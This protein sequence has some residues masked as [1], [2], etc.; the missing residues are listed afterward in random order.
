MQ[1]F[2]IIYT[3]TNEISRIN[4]KNKK[5]KD[6]LI[7]KK[8]FNNYV[9]TLYSNNNINHEWINYII[10]FE[11]NDDIHIYF[12][13]YYI[14]KVNKNDVITIENINTLF[15]EIILNIKEINIKLPIDYLFDILIEINLN[16]HILL[17]KKNKDN[18]IQIEFKIINNNIHFFI[19][20]NIFYECSIE[21]FN[22][23]QQDI[24]NKYISIEKN[25]QKILY[26]N[27]QANLFD[28]EDTICDLQEYM[29]KNGYWLDITFNF[30]KNRFQNNV[31]M[32]N[33]Y[34]YFIKYDIFLFS[35]INCFK[36]ILSSLDNNYIEE[37][38]K[39]KIFIFIPYSYSYDN[40]KL[41]WKYKDFF[42]I[43]KKNN[44]IFIGCRN[45]DS[46][47]RIS[48][49]RCQLVQ[50]DIHI[51]NY[52]NTFNCFNCDILIPVLNTKNDSVL[53]KNDFFKIHKLD[54]NKPLITFFIIWPIR[55]VNPLIISTGRFDFDNEFWANDG[56]INEFIANLKD[57]YNI[58]F[59]PHPG[60]IKID[61]N[62]LYINTDIYTKDNIKSILNFYN[63][64][65]NTFKQNII[66][67][68]YNHEIL[69]Y[70]DFGIVSY[71]STICNELY[72][73]DIPLL[74]LKSK[75]NDWT[76]ICYNGY[77]ELIDYLKNNK[78]N[79]NIDK[80][81]NPINIVYGTSEFIDNIEDDYKNKLNKIINKN[82]K[83]TYKYFKNHP[84]YGNTYD[85]KQK[86]IGKKILKILNILNNINTYDNSKIRYN[87]NKYNI[88][89]YNDKYINVDIENKIITIKI[90]KEPLINDHF[91]SYGIHLYLYS[92]ERLCTINLSFD[93]KLKL[94]EDNIYFRLYTGIKWIIYKDKP[95]TTNFT[96]LT[97]TENFNFI[98]T[99]KWRMSINS[100]I[101]GQEII[102]KNL[103]IHN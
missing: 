67:F 39:N 64:H 23:L 60:N 40:F 63:I 27:Q 17:L 90:I 89:I 15:K 38:I 92:L 18:K 20:N 99:S 19:K 53:S 73:N 77:N 96:N 81:I 16:H 66:D 83:S 72:I 42:N 55:I 82:Y 56:Y 54:L 97:I 35:N 25:K 14:K 94:N 6:N 9:N 71:G 78:F 80:I 93:I 102:I 59:K 58:I 100:K 49:W 7:F 30:N 26:F 4:P 57:D 65:N 74:L 22:N 52:V 31:Y 76:K 47:E 29:Y 41:I 75:K 103:N 98:D 8:I 45:L 50:N 34:N 87:I 61:I 3:N 37:Y 79:I 1:T 62:K 69:K 2:E 10:F 12:K 84:F 28:C 32:Q 21:E 68:D 48:S 95:L 33:R 24:Y 36:G 86:N 43:I 46:I 44:T 70:T 91:I 13:K 51:F 11:I 101:V 88:I 5:L 85:L